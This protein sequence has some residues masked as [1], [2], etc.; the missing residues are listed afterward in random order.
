MRKQYYSQIG[1]PLVFAFALCCV[2]FG[3]IILCSCNRTD[4]KKQSQEQ[5]CR[6]PLVYSLVDLYKQDFVST[7]G[8]PLKGDYNT[9]HFL[10][11]CKKRHIF[12][13]PKSK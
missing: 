4:K 12:A 13:V 10:D 1:K 2:L 6:M 3:D 5:E 8:F 9:T 11:N 7:Y